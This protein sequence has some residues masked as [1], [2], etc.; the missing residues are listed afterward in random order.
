LP[1][2]GGIVTYTEKVT[3]LGEVALSNVNLTDDKC[4]PVKYISGD[5]NGDAKLDNDETWVYT[6]RTKLTKTTTN[7]VTASGEADGLTARD[8]AI[9]TVVVATAVPKLPNTGVAPEDNSAFEN[10]VL[11]F[12]LL[13]LVSISVVIVLKKRKT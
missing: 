13:M 10:I 9:V 11:F 5:T 12:G 3:N 2:G 6:C 8:F 7:T 1:A 4:S